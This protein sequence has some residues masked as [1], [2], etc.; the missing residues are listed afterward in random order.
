MPITV[1]KHLAEGKGRLPICGDKVVVHYTGWLVG[2][3]G[4]TGRQFDSSRERGFAMTFTVGVG[5]VIEGWEEAVQVRGTC[6]R[7][8]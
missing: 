6:A 3:G 2:T 8:T 1:L 4:T 5:K 7:E